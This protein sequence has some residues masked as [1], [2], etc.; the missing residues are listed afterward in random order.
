MKTKPTLL[1]V[2][3]LFAL[4][5]RSFGQNELIKKQIAAI[6]A[7]KHQSITA[8]VQPSIMKI[9]P[10]SAPNGCIVAVVGDNIAANPV[11]ST[12]LQLI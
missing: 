8:T 11:K 10:A 9:T 4:T 3:I 1:L 2:A 5:I 6:A 7:P 12:N